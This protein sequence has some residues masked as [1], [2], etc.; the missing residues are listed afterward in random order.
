MEKR[1]K[2]RKGEWKAVIFSLLFSASLFVSGN[3][4]LKN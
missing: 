3:K 4:F 2:K 1:G